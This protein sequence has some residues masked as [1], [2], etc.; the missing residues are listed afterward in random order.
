M[1]PPSSASP[2]GLPRSF[3]T[4]DVTFD[5]HRSYLVPGLALTLH[6]GLQVLDRHG[7]RTHAP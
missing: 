7:E 1:E 6:K 2:P 3:E 4:V 5:G